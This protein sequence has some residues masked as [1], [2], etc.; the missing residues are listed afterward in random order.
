MNIIITEMD[1]EGK[2]EVSAVVFSHEECEN[3]EQLQKEFSPN[4]KVIGL[5]RLPDD[6]NLAILLM[7]LCSFGDGLE[8]SFQYEIEKLLAKIFNLGKEYKQ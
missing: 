1:V 2:K 8:E 3:I 7:S 4:E 5:V 6:D